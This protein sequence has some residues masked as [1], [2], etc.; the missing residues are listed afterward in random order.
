MWD[1]ILIK[2]G[3]H[4]ASDNVFHLFTTDKGEQDW[5]LVGI[6]LSLSPFLRTRVII[7]I[8]QSLG[9]VC[10]ESDLLVKITWRTGVMKGASSL[11]T[12]G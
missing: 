1:V 3:H 9:T 7:A 6:G 5:K 10:V 4:A 8:F 2:V 11:S 12:L